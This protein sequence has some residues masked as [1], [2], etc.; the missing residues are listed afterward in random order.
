MPELD[1]EQ[2]DA[3][4]FDMDGVITDTATIHAS[5]WKHTFDA[6]LRKRAEQQN[7]ECC[8]F[9]IEKD[10]LPYVDGKPRY[11]GVKSFLES[12][13]ISLPYGSL[14]DSP[15]L[16]TICGLGN[17]KNDYFHQLLE[18]GQVRAYESSLDFVRKLVE[19]GVSVAVISAS[20][21][22]KQ[23]LRAAG[24]LDFFP[25]VVDGLDSAELNL[26][27]K[28]EPDI[29]LEAAKRLGATPQRSAIVEDALAGVAAGRA[30]GFARVIGVDRTGQGEALRENGAGMVVDDLSEI[31]LEAASSKLSDNSTGGSRDLPSALD[32]KDEILSAL[33]EGT[34][35]IALDFED[36]LA[37]LL[38]GPA[39]VSLAPRVQKA[40]K[41]LSEC[42]MVAVIGEREMADI[43]RTVGVGGIYYAGGHGFE[44]CDPSGSY[45][46]DEACELH[47]PELDAVESKLNA[48]LADAAEAWLERKRFTLSVKYDKT[49]LGDVS[50][51][52]T[53][54]E[55]VLS[56]HTTLRMVREDNVFKLT[57]DITRDKAQVLTSLL[58][59][60]LIDSSSAV[61]LY[62][63]NGASSGEVFRAMG[64]KGIGIDTGDRR[65]K[66]SAK[67]SLSK[68]SEAVDLLEYLAGMA[69]KSLSRGIWKLAYEGFEPEHEGLR[70]ALCT[71]GNGYFATRGAAPESS[72]DGI[73]Y[74]GTYLAGCYNRLTSEVEG[75][76]IENESL[77][78]V[79]NWLPLS[80]R[81][82]DGEWFDV[83]SVELHEYRQELDVQRGVLSRFIRFSD[84]AG[85]RT[86]LAQRR[87]VHMANPHLAGLETTITAENWSGDL[88]IRSALDGRV[89]NTGVERYR[90]LDNDHL[91][92]VTDGS[93]GDEIIFVQVETNQSHIR[94]AEAARTRL[95]M[96]DK[97]IP[98]TPR[99]GSEPGY[100]EQE[101]HLSIKEEHPVTVEKIAAIYNS[102][103]FAISES[104]IEAKR[105]IS[106]AASFT[107]LLSEHIL[108]WHHLWHRCH[109]TVEDSEQVARILNLHIFHLLQTVSINS[110]DLD[111]GVPPRGL[112][113][114]AYRG[115]ILWDEI[116]IFPF[117]N[118]RI[119]DI[120][121]ALLMY[122]Y[123]RL[124]EARFMARAA[125]YRGAM[126]PWQSGSDGREES[127]S[128]HLNP[129][130][131]RWIEDNS[132]LQRH[133]NIAIAYNVWN[134][135]EVTGDLSF[136]AFYGAE[137][138]I[139]I[140]RFWASA[141][142]Y[143]RS[144]DRY[145]I[146]KVM[147]PDEF[148]EGYPD[149]EEPGIDNNAYTNVMVAWLMC[150]TLDTLD[151]LSPHRHEYIWEDMGLS[152]DEL[153]QWDDIS[154]KMRIP[155]HDGVISQ[156]EH[157]DGL[158]EFD[159]K[160]YKEKYGNIQ[161]LDRILEAEDDTPNRY[162]LSKQA[163]ALMLFYLLSADELRDLF[164]RMGYTFE[165]ETIP[166]S[167][168][169][170]IKRTSHGSTLSRVVH[171]W[172]LS[173][174]QREVSW[175][176]FR[177]ALASDISD[178][179]GGTT[180][181]GIHLGAMAGT[182]DLIQR[183]YTGMETRGNVLMF[184][185][186][187]PE[188]LSNLEFDIH[189][190]QS[191]L[192]VHIDKKLL[193]VT[194]LAGEVAPVNIG[195]E[196]HTTE[197]KPGDSVE[198]ELEH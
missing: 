176:L 79:P 52:E 177:D 50:E 114:E 193:K 131:G 162:K 133:I 38:E 145:E 171:S 59:S 28:P 117:L 168:D 138:L 17:R 175:H 156:F 97:V 57:P 43:E 76:S 36:V 70:E 116:F 160:R 128:I 34:P 45:I 190:R 4:I 12:R 87:F 174:S 183:C 122:R 33:Q 130:S 139:E 60:V 81:F 27:G 22:C 151:L 109:L 166:A 1:L 144:L 72:A 188:A 100:V 40:I 108:S 20:K 65:Q 196:D 14:D 191:A 89:K 167:V 192:N 7:E 141:A 120:T 102:R 68:P 136:L 75:Q 112:H 29:F 110:I 113:G 161:R 169:Y 121:R 47:L 55:R 129:R 99:I 92:P 91:A 137:M 80:F 143:N 13:G 104:L 74:P 66:N 198:F 149:R 54:L 37:P 119:P 95:I 111:A 101:F 197:L 44:V 88:Y 63:G 184:N 127:Q 93:I 142:Q 103:D 152:R 140:A 61:P 8:P 172:V 170:Y 58:D 153:K 15:N 94:I 26:K 78:N 182:V 179:Q 9:D 31:S 56:E 146:R 10:Y 159:W 41:R 64:K 187:L 134:Y 135:Y 30:G 105:E 195:F 67:Y 185:P 69:E 158:E 180:R 189:Y 148:H 194:C 106:R 35:A 24:A 126:Y 96:E 186:Y 53:L 25:V 85:R 107:E 115:H 163:D 18:E 98:A 86:R 39:N 178:V 125:G 132:H 147:G 2:I 154:R 6:Y 23:V 21:N 123:R 3:V 51:L 124:P 155:F 82:G 71:L 11:D 42:W 32:N 62:I 77:V 48:F 173:R 84:E 49:K 83:G 157:Y 73:H 118:F 181:E 164:N 165:Y 150:R 19:A 5:A 16:E 46:R 90:S